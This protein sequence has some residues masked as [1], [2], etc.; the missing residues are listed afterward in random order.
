MLM[1]GLIGFTAIFFIFA[2]S[3]E[4]FFG[5]NL[6]M[7]KIHRYESQNLDWIANGMSEMGTPTVVIAVIIVSTI[8]LWIMHKKRYSIMC[9]LLVL[10]YLSTAI[11]K[12]LIARSRP[13]LY[14]S[15]SIF[16][17]FGFPSGHATAAMLVLG[18]FIYLAQSLVSGLR[19]KFAIQVVLILLILVIGLSRIYLTA[20][21]PSDI[22]G[23]FL[24]GGISLW[25]IIWASKKYAVKSLFQ[26]NNQHHIEESSSNQGDEGTSRGE[27]K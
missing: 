15:P 14:S 6:I 3:F 18:F 23:G 26:G 17:G 22:I 25:I 20:H 13:D 21:W 8:V 1:L 10:P 7:K 5:D 16:D 12:N 19:L 11:T 9:I 4:T 2:A 24:Y 27:T